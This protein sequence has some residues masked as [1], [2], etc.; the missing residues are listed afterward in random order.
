MIKYIWTTAGFY[1]ESTEMKKPYIVPEVI[2]TPLS[3]PVPLSTCT[4]MPPLSFC[5]CLCFFP[6]CLL[7]FSALFVGVLEKT[8]EGEA[9]ALTKAKTL[10]KS[11]TNESA[12]AGIRCQHRLFLFVSSIVLK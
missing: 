10:Y 12:S 2:Y 9:A 7:C 5:L 11:C 3:F 4:L 8:V 6:S 1:F